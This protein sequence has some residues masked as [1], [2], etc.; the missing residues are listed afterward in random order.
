MARKNCNEGRSEV[1]KRGRERREGWDREE[2]KGGDRKRVGRGG[3]KRSR[4]EETPQ[5]FMMT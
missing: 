2:G 1:G 4:R 3:H 5:Q